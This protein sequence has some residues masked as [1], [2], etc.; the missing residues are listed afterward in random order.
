LGYQLCNSRACS[1]FAVTQAKV[2]F[3]VPPPQTDHDLLAYRIDS[4]RVAIVT[5]TLGPLSREPSETVRPIARFIPQLEVVPETHDARPAFKGDLAM[6]ADWTVSSNGAR[7][8]SVAEQPAIVSSSCGG[9]QGP[10]VIIAR[11]PDKRFANEPSKYFL[12][13][14]TGRGV[15]SG[16]LSVDLRLD[17]AQRRELDA[18][19]DKQMRITVPTAF[20]PD[21]VIQDP[22]QQPQETEYDR[23]VRSG[24]AR[25]VYHLEAFKLAPDEDPRLYIRAYWTASSKAQTGLTLWMRFDG[26]HFEVE[27][28]DAAILWFAR[29]LEKKELG[30]DVASRADYAGVLLNVIPAGDGWAYIIMGQQGYDGAGVT[31]LKYSPTGPRE[32]GIAFSFGC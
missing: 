32:A 20:A 7:Y 19:I 22:S 31:V 12:A 17:D 10:L 2:K 3:T 30:T 13:S 15:N 4:Q 8:A 5:E 6:G 25:L 29:Y 28:T 24:Q 26:H 16:P 9:N 14:R 18:V 23:R 27:Q 21:P 1:R 11:V